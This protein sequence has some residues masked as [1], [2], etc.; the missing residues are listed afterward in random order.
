MHTLFKYRDEVINF[1][2]MCI[3]LGCVV[4][5]A[6]FA[7]RIFVWASGGAWKRRK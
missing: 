3:Q 5:L 4:Y 7:V 6:H 1:V 2:L